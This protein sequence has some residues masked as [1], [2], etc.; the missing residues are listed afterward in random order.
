MDTKPLRKQR[1]HQAPRRWCGNK[2]QG[3]YLFH[4]HTVGAFLACTALKI[5]NELSSLPAWYPRMAM[6]LYKAT[7][8]FWTSVRRCL[9][10]CQMPSLSARMHSDA[11][12]PAGPEGKACLSL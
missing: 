4:W 12:I 1:A 5:R 6:H 9:E 10:T 7:H 2:Q 11:V 8:S 3:R